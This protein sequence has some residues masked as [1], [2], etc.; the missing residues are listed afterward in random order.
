[1][2]IPLNVLLVEDSE[3][4]AQLVLRELHKAGYDLSYT[5]VDSLSALRKV[6]KDKKWQVIIADYSMPSFSGLDA[7]KLMRE[8]GLDLPFLL[9]SGTIG[10][11]LA[12]AAMRAGAHDYLMK[13]DLARLIPAVHRELQ[14]AKE[15]QARRSA[16]N[17]LRRRAEE[18]AALHRASMTI[19]ESHD[20]DSLILTI[21]EQAAQLMHASGAGVCV[22]DPN[23]QEVTVYE[24]IGT[25]GRSYRGLV[26]QYG[27]GAAGIVAQTGKP[28]IIDD[29]RSWP[30]RAAVYEQEKPY[31]ATLSVPMT[32]HGE[33]T[34]V[35]QVTDND[36]TRHFTQ[37]DAELLSLLGDQVAI[38]IENTRLLQA[39][40]TVRE[41][42]EALREAA[43][44]L[45]LRSP[46]EVLQAVLDQL[47]RAAF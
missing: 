19:T 34:G 4:D 38:A 27:E 9:V 37:S 46:D 5:R 47:A 36:E 21:I 14:E 23:K 28:L 3:D 32:W 13:D 45:G 10:E 41:Q 8:M 39:E 44:S 7:L 40:R 1:M 6:I 18:L 22:C 26:L 15:R 16:E 20:M 43:R 12:V 30:N 31:T 17:E 35:L 33:V 42:A 29:Y 24:E 11:D 25:G 2:T